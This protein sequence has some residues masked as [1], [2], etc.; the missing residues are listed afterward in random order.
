MQGSHSRHAKPTPGWVL[1]SAKFCWVDLLQGSFRSA[2]LLNAV[3]PARLGGR[4]HRDCRPTIAS[5]AAPDG[6]LDVAA[7]TSRI[8]R[9]V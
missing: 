1:G 3:S 6:V 8:G 5:L 9:S 7:A 4:S 2:D